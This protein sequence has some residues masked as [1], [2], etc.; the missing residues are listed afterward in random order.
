[1][2]NFNS[3]GKKQY[4]SRKNTNNEVDSKSIASDGGE[5]K[6]QQMNLIKDNNLN[7]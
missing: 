6:S 7:P 1:M 3:Q 2:L 5:S 4:R